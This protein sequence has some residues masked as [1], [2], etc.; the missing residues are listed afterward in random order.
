MYALIG[1]WLLWCSGVPRA[2]ACHEQRSLLWGSAKNAPIHQGT[3]PKPQAT[4][5]VSSMLDTLEVLRELG[6]KLA[7]YAAA[8]RSDG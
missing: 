5:S 7:T 2:A 4:G 1:C 3:T 8:L 6:R